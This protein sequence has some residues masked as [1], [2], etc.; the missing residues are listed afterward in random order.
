MD[1]LIV[2]WD[3]LIDIEFPVGFSHPLDRPD[4]EIIH[5]ELESIDFLDLDPSLWIPNPASAIQT[6][7][8]IRLRQIATQSW[9]S[10]MVNRCP[11]TGVLVVSRFQGKWAMAFF[12]P[13]KA[14]FAILREPSDAEA[15]A[16]L[17]FDSAPG[18][19]PERVIRENPQPGLWMAEVDY[20]ISALYRTDLQFVAFS[21]A[22]ETQ[23]NGVLSGSF[24]PIHE[25]HQKMAEHATNSKKLNIT[26]EL[27][28]QNAEKPPL[29]QFEI[30]ER[31]QQDFGVGGE[32]AVALSNAATF[33][34]KSSLFPGTTFLVGFDTLV[35]IADQAYYNGIRHR[36]QAIENIAKRNCRILVYGRKLVMD[37]LEDF[38]QGNQP[39]LLKDLAD[40]CEWVPESEFRQD[41][42]ST[43]K[44]L[45]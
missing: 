37:G 23:A 12:S 29:D 33:E 34:E 35:R 27:A 9:I 30:W 38:W 7:E 5:W 25:G 36:D 40:L 1:R 6:Q 43:E 32:M 45:L 17:I 8:G 11:S 19:F 3:P 20:E 44:R 22:A 39:G 28:I 26:F 24:A 10:S 41:M 31:S 4:I 16:K 2:I 21:E 15:V 13:A 14:V 42:T 18:T